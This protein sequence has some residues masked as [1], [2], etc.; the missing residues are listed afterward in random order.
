VLALTL[1]VGLPASYLAYHGAG[2]TVDIVLPVVA[3]CALGVGAEALRRRRLVDSF[4]RYVGR[5]VMRAVL[6]DSALLRGDR[7]E[8]SILV[9]DLRGFT[10]LSETMPAERVAAH[11]NEYFPA[12]IEAIFGQRGMIND[13]IGDGILA[14][15]GA[16]LADPDHAVR[17]A[18]AAMA[19]Q[20]AL[21]RLNRDWATRGLPALRMGIGVHTGTVFAGN[22][23]G[24]ER[25]KYTVVGDAVNVTARLE[26]LNKDL[27]TTTLVTEETRQAIGDRAET[28]YRG[29]VPVKGR[30][31]PLKVHEL[32][33]VRG[34]GD[35]ASE[36]RGAERRA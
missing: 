32:L 22:V 14:V 25:I 27:A 10:T 24:P 13:F 19:M 7:R 31:E 21:A 15:F 5:E 26:S 36:G 17:A 20:E 11:L 18:R 6:A 35:G 16:P 33:A 8:V 2:Y 4:G 23:G 28:R 3:T 1:A 30:A 9:S 34:D 29:E 12:M